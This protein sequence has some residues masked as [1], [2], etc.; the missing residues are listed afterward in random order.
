MGKDGGTVVSLT[1][2]MDG[3][4]V[5]KISF[6]LCHVLARQMAVHYSILFMDSNFF[7]SGKCNRRIFVTTVSCLAVLGG[8]IKCSNALGTRRF[9]GPQEYSRVVP[10]SV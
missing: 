3:K 9:D 2:N 4:L 6:E 1:E 10:I 8:H 7:R 5:E